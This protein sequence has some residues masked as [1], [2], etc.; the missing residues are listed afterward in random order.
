MN[1]HYISYIA[2][3][4]NLAIWQIENC[5]TLFN[6]GATVPFIARYR[7][8]KS[9][10]MDEVEV[11]EVNHFF[12]YFKE[13]DKRKESIIKTVREQGKL[14]Q[15][16]L[17][18]I[19]QTVELARLE[20]LYL[21]FKPK[22]TSRASI[23]KENGLEELAN[24]IL[25]GLVQNP[26]K[27]ASKYISEKYPSA[28]EAVAGARDI[29]AELV[30]E[31]LEVREALRLRYLQD[32]RL[33]ATKRASV[34]EESAEVSKYKNY[35]NFDAPIQKIPSHR[36]LALLRGES[37]KELSLKLQVES[38]TMERL[39]KSL[40]LSKR[41]TL[42][43]G[44]KDEVES[45]I[46]DSYKRLLHP[47]IENE[48]LKI[49]KERA[50]KEAIKVFSQNL[51]SLLLAPPVGE[52]RILAIDPG[53]RTG[54]K[55]VCLDTN[56]DLLHNETIYP[57]PPINERV[58]AIKKISNLVQS[59]KIEVIAIGNG[60]AGRE[61]E[62]FMKK[63]AL[64]PTIAIYSVSEDGASIYS[65]S[66]V[67]REEF[68]NYDV[69]VRGAVSIG[70]RVMD[71]L[72]E[73]VKI[74]PKSLGIGQYQHDVNQKSLQEALDSTVELCVNRVG[75][76]LNTASKHL[77]SYVSGIG[78]SL[79]ERAVEYRSKIGLF[80]T[81]T[82]LMDVNG[83]GPKK[84]EQC[85]GFLRVPNGTHP[86]DN[87]AVHPERY[88]LVEKIALDYNLSIEQLI[89]QKESQAKIELERYISPETSK[90]TLQDIL[91]EIAK[92]GLDPRR[93]AKVLEFSPEVYSIE[94][95][96]VGMILPGVVN[97][98]TNFGA[99][100][101]IGVGEDG[102]AHI[103]QL[104]DRFIKEPTEVLKLHQHV[105]VKILEVDLQR[106]RIALSLRGVEQ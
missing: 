102:L 95:L 105:K 56:G 27:E 25:N 103:S 15:E 69:T 16:L 5:I 26:L 38:S 54:C 22:R 85:A 101:D 70:R 30:S 47:S 23:A 96:E 78:P 14:S 82:Q 87:T 1:K 63:I 9:G 46:I 29:I 2:N 67:A 60:T 68:P 84:F 49:V 51:I 33:I 81:K 99:F 28:S 48:T 32:G 79:A 24:S 19:E 73:L 55:V 52:K 31:T 50:D 97:N 59:Y 34:A 35:F 8:E 61:T 53:F 104:A 77:L 3:N 57:H 21:P 4:L 39:I 92:P 71:P 86:L 36:V 62:N 10:D 18:S 106:R 65:A 90:T 93:V 72:A 7:K 91:N 37:E 98:I 40:F 12:K 44:C 66:A 100:I 43:K 11:A 13:L 42:S 20:D 45:A 74:D 76:N 58:K 6:E 83:F 64:P 80:K 94:Q 17:K 88:P 89:L 75:I 41:D